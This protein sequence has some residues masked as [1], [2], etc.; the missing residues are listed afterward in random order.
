MGIRRFA[1]KRLTIFSLM[2]FICV[3]AVAIAALRNPDNY[4]A[5]GMILM[6]PLIVGFVLIGALCGAERLRARRLGFAIFGGGYFALAFLGLREPNLRRLPTSQLL[7]TIHDLAVP[8]QV[9]TISL[10]TARSRTSTSTIEFT[11]S[12]PFPSNL[13][14]TTATT[15]SV[16]ATLIAPNRWN[17]LLPGAAN[18]EAFSIVGHCLFTLLFGVLGAAIAQWFRNRRKRAAEATPEPAP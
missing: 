8:P 12:K 2:G 14:T 10:T 3:V 1:M 16:P 7:S 6:T 9:Y 17:L 4:W 13:G 5:S 11:N 18:Y 15:T